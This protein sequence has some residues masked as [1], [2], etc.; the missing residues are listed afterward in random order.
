MMISSQ[1]V[2]GDLLKIHHAGVVHN[3]FTDRH[4]IAKK[5]ADLNPERPWYPMIVDF[6]EAK[7]DHN[8]PYKD[9]KVE[10]YI[11]APARADFKC[12]ELYVACRDTAQLWHS[13]HMEVFGVACPIEWADDGPEASAKMA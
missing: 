2:V 9:N 3:D 5:L 10:T 12:A 1:R 6:G 8:C 7:M 4:I 13:N 11:R